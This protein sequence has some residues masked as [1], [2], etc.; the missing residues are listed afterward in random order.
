MSMDALSSSDLPSMFTSILHTDITSRLFPI[1]V[2]RDDVLQL[3][4]IFTHTF[5]LSTNSSHV[6]ADFR[7]PLP[8]LSLK[9][10]QFDQGTFSKVFYPFYMTTPSQNIFLNFNYYIFHTAFF[11]YHIPYPVTQFF[12]TKLF[13]LCPCH[14][15]HLT[16]ILTNIKTSLRRGRPSIFDENEVTGTVKNTYYCIYFFYSIS[17]GHWVGKG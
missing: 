4:T 9:L 7:N 15:F 10:A 5:L 3:G 11:C 1:G 2:G 6:R 8:N 13:F 14:S 16:Y 12:S 17:K